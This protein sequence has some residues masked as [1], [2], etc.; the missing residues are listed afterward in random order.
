MSFG[1]WGRLRIYNTTESSSLTAGALVIDGGVSIVKDLRIGGSLIHDDVLTLTNQTESSSIISGALVVHGGVGIAGNVYA[2]GD[3]FSNGIRLARTNEI[4][5]TAGTNIDIISQVVSVESAPTFSGIV[6]LT[7]T[8]NSSSTSTGALVVDGGLAVKKN[9]S[10]G[11]SSVYFGTTSG[12][13]ALKAPASVPT[14]YTFTLPTN[15]PS[16]ADYAIVSDTSGNLSFAPLNSDTTGT[17]TPITFY[18]G[19]NVSTPA[20]VTGFLVLGESYIYQVTSVVTAVSAG[21]S[22]T[23]LYVL[24]GATQ[25]D[26]TYTLD[27]EEISSKEQGHFF[28]VLPSRQVQYTAPNIADWIS[29]SFSI[30]KIDQTS[31]KGTTLSTSEILVVA[32]TQPSVSTSS[33]ALTVQGGI[34]VLGNVNIGGSLSATTLSGTLTT[35]LQPNIT[36]IGT[37]TSLTSSGIVNIIDGTNVTATT[38]NALN[39]TGSIGTAGNLNVGRR[40]KMYT[41]GFSGTY[42]TGGNILSLGSGTFTE[43][44]TVSSGT[45][46]SYYHAQIGAPTLAYSNT[47]VTTSLATT[48]LIDGAPIQGTN[49]TLSDIN[50]YSLQ[51][52]SGQSEFNTFGVQ[53]AGTYPLIVTANRTLAEYAPTLLLENR[54]GGLGTAV[55]IDFL[56]YSSSRSKPAASLRAIDMNNLITDIALYTKIPGAISNALAERIRFDSTGRI[57]LFRSAMSALVS[58]TGNIIDVPAGTFTDTV[59]S[60]ST[61]HSLWS[62]TYLGVTTLASTNTSISSTNAATLY[63]A[64]SPVTGTNHAI[65]TSYSLWSAGGVN[66]FDGVVSI[67]NNTA[68]TTVSSGALLVTG[69]VGVVGQVTAGTVSATTLTGTLSSAAQPNVTS[70]GTLT[71]LTASGTIT[72]GN[73]TTAGIVTGVTLAGT[74]STVA[75]PNVTSLGTLTSLTSS[76]AIVISNATASTSTVSGALRVAGG[77]GVVGQVTAATVLATTL[78]GT[79]ST[80]AQAT[81]TSL[82]TLTGLTTSGDLVITSATASSSTTTGALRVAGGI[83]VVGQVS[84]GTISATTLTGTLSTAAQLNVT[85]LGTLTGLT[86]SGAVTITNTNAATSSTT[87]ALTITGG[88]GVSGDMWS[89]RNNWTDGTQVYRTFFANTVTGIGFDNS[90]TAVTSARFNFLSSGA[91]GAYSTETRHYAF[92]IPGGANQESLSMTYSSTGGT[93]TSLASGSGVTRSL[94]IYGGTV[95]NTDGTLSITN[96]TAATTTTT[97]A[98][99]VSGGV[100]ISGA[101]HAA[102]EISSRTTGTRAGLNCVTAGGNFAIMSADGDGAGDF[103]IYDLGSNRGVFGYFRTVNEIVFAN[104]TSVAVRPHT[105]NFTV[106]GTST[107]RWKEVWS[108]NGTLQTSDARAKRDINVISGTDALTFLSKID[109]VTYHWKDNTS[110]K[111]HSGIIAQNLLQ[112]LQETFTDHDEYALVHKPENPEE[113][114][115]VNYGE[116][117][118]FL[119][120][121]HKETLHQLD[122]IKARLVLLEGSTNS[123]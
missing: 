57:M 32:N 72:G 87:G 67:V 116:L 71:S 14:P 59:S 115:A 112:G 105:D 58:T 91:T 45:L 7:L 6:S 92:G 44:S 29:T 21:N 121:A 34:G 119:I 94:T 2:G 38:G 83:G 54:N 25:V 53:T 118:A 22:T 107:K 88:L 79:L 98:L 70:L 11:G 68:S 42:S 60:T 74:L 20:N 122:A 35:A 43:S 1:K 8:V 111:K 16:I 113:N 49:N 99:R 56:T 73:L 69:G 9:I 76:G 51:V 109:P 89:S 120:A 117:I 114:Y 10:I 23:S 24:S 62:G 106:L 110:S 4:V 18:A 41:S 33:G 102:G 65:G 96:A 52:A 77:I 30:R 13:V 93:I 100:G 61:V 81:V 97:G 39:V 12:N 37:V 5:Y 101:L 48:L 55:G 17:T 36:S 50:R 64:G 19:N 95:F 63:I 85:S 47:G 86:S 90:I 28:T 123:S 103:H 46:S 84:A 15:L 108:A 3:Y 40:L 78:T 31:I 80:A 66:R 75:Q 104:S 82:G 26:G 27:V